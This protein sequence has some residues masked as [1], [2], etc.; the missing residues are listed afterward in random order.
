MVKKKERGTGGLFEKL[1]KKK[2]ERDI[3][4]SLGGR[5]G[6]RIQGRK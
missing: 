2:S 5:W 1:R 6:G 3:R 4:T